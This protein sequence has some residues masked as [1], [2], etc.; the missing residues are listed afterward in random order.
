MAVHAL[1]VQPPRRVSQQAAP[2]STKFTV[3]LPPVAASAPAV[4]LPPAAASAP[5]PAC[6]G[7]SATPAAVPARTKEEGGTAACVLAGTSE[8]GSRANALPA[9]VKTEP[10]AAAEVPPA[11]ALPGVPA[12]GVRRAPWRS[13]KRRADVLVAAGPAEPAAPQPAAAPAA[14]RSGRQAAAA[15]PS[16]P[17]A[18]K[19]RR[20]QVRR[21]GLAGRLCWGTP[22]RLS[23]QVQL[24]RFARITISSLHTHPAH[25][26]GHARRPGAGAA[27]ARHEGAP[28]AG[29][30]SGVPACLLTS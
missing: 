2:P 11:A 30:P 3:W 6:D 22:Q 16:S 8:G 27:P 14:R 7:G 21:E 1:R 9:R 10:S 19:A 4:W 18:K 23:L 25:L 15:A 5:A 29:G 17:A 20:A 28:R 24:T 13:C 12:G 26:A